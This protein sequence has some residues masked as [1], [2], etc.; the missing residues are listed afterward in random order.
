MH[1]SYY[2]MTLMPTLMFEADSL[3]HFSFFRFKKSLRKIV[4]AHNLDGLH[5]DLAQMGTAVKAAKIEKIF[6]WFLSEYPDLKLGV[7]FSPNQLDKYQSI[8][9]LASMV[10][11]KPD[12]TDLRQA[13]PR[14]GSAMRKRVFLSVSRDLEATLGDL[15]FSLTRSVSSLTFRPFLGDT[16]INQYQLQGLLLCQR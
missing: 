16:V 7:T 11:I 2:K 14:L 9:E 10:G 8:A 13:L 1:R 12:A 6:R 3:D 5:F 4:K 15:Q